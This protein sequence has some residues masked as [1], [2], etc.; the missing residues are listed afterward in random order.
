MTANKAQLALVVAAISGCG[1]S[2]SY[3]YAPQTTNEIS[4]NLPAART[5]IPQEAPQGAVEVASYGITHLHPGGA[6]VPVLHVRMIVTNDGDDTPWTVD[7]R[8]QFVEIEG[9][10][11]SRAM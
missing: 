2:Q 8:E 5:P 6:N 1:E 4:A 11:R 9:E 3:V 7:T 10:G